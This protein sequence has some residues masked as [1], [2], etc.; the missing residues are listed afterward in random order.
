MAGGRG[1]ISDRVLDLTLTASGCALGVGALVFLIPFNAPRGVVVYLT[2]FFLLGPIL[3]LSWIEGQRIRTDG[4]FYTYLRLAVGE[5]AVILGPL[6]AVPAAPEHGKQVA[7]DVLVGNGHGSLRGKLGR[8][9][10]TVSSQ[11]PATVGAILQTIEAGR[12]FSRTDP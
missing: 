4:R 7:F 3:Y 8:K 1:H 10:T 2:V 5:A 6:V 12:S 11:D 9:V